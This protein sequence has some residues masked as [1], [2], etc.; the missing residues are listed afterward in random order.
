MNVFHRVWLVIAALVAA[1]ALSGCGWLFFSPV[2]PGSTIPPVT[3]EAPAMAPEPGGDRH[4]DVLTV[5]LRPQPDGSYEAAVTLSSPYDTPERYA[6]GWRVLDPVGSTLG[7]H[8]LL[9]DHAN[10]QPFTR[11]QRGLM[12]PTGVS[13]VTVEGRDQANGFGGLTITVAVPD[14]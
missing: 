3:V 14:G 8:T 2:E 13:Q 12:I 5:E 1:F 4:P 7:T 6:D 10:E 9:H 11:T